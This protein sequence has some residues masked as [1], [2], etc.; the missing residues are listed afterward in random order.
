MRSLEFKDVLA[1]ERDEIVRFERKKLSP[2]FRAERDEEN[3]LRR[4]GLL[5]CL[6]WAENGNDKLVVKQVLMNTLA[7]YKR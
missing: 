3:E 5:L 7:K 4:G 2:G 6:L 1:R